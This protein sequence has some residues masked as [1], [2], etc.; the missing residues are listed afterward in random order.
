MPVRTA[1]ATWEGSVTDGKGTITAESGV[2]DAANSLSMRTEDGVSA[3]NPEEL[4]ACAHAGC[5][6]MMLSA[7]LTGAGY[8]PE[9]ID[10]T[11]RIH[12][13]VNDDGLRI[14]KSELTTRARVPEVDDTAFQRLAQE[15]KSA[16]PVSVALAGLDDIT[17][18]ATLEG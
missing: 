15:A 9:R 5:Y 18:Q 7:L 11:A 2:V 12:L 4:I 16:C 17:L 10:T 3:T 14:V 1:Q 6:S 13:A 8:P